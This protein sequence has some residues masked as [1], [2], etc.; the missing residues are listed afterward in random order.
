MTTENE[1][2]PRGHRILAGIREEEKMLEGTCS[3]EEEGLI[4]YADWLS[5]DDFNGKRFTDFDPTGKILTLTRMYQHF[6]K[7]SL[8]TEDISDYMHALRD[9]VNDYFTQ[10]HDVDFFFREFSDDMG[11]SIPSPQ[12]IQWISEYELISV[13]SDLM[14]LIWMIKINNKRRILTYDLTKPSPKHIRLITLKD[15]QAF[16]EEMTLNF[17]LLFDAQDFYKRLE[18]GFEEGFSIS[19]AFQELFFAEPFKNMQDYLTK[20]D[21]VKAKLHEIEDELETDDKGN[22]VLSDKIAFQI[23]EVPEAI[24]KLYK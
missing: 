6:E 4:N 22:Y 17:E 9:E 7:S 8:T 3:F 13:F 24:Q 11:G 10:K 18:E 19:W 23:F 15:Y 16:F 21:W 2:S 1:L 20:M 12:A 5:N 14:K